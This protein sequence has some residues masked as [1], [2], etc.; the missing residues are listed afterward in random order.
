[1]YP[2]SP[3]SM[4][5]SASNELCGLVPMSLLKR[6]WNTVT[7]PSGRTRS[8]QSTIVLDSQGAQH[9]L[10]HGFVLWAP[11]K[12][13]FGPFIRFFRLGRSR[14]PVGGLRKTPAKRFQVS[15]LGL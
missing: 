5:G 14:L 12:E 6:T 3:G 15:F 9:L 1:M 11:V 13:C 7:T 4:T 2:Y 10:F 8:G